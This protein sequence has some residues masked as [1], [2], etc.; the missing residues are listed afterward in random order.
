[1]DGSIVGFL[2]GTFM[3]R[4]PKRTTNDYVEFLSRLLLHDYNGLMYY[5]N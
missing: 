3:V 5:Y 4:A 2:R 1:M